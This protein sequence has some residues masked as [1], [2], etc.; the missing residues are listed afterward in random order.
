MGLSISRPGFFTD[1]RPRRV[2][3][4]AGRHRLR[5]RWPPID[6]VQLEA[7]ARVGLFAAQRE[8]YQRQLQRVRDFAF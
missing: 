5:G 6:L 8:L 2:L 7:L 4:V 3:L 1:P